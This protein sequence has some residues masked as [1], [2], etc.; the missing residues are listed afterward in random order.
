[1]EIVGSIASAATNGSTLYVVGRRFFGDLS[2][3]QA[4]A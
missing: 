3:W 1:M 4:L 2:R